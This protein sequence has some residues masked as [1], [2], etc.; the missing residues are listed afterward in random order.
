MLMRIDRLIYALAAIILA[1][2]VSCKREEPEADDPTLH[3]AGMSQ[4]E[5]ESRILGDWYVDIDGSEDLDIGFFELDIP[6][7][8]SS[9]IAR[10]IYFDDGK[11]SGTESG[12]GE[13]QVA[14]LYSVEASSRQEFKFDLVTRLDKSAYPD[15]ID[16][17]EHE[18]GAVDYVL[19][20]YGISDITEETLTL[21]FTA[22]EE[23]QLDGEFTFQRGSVDIASLDLQKMQA[24]NMEIT[25]AETIADTDTT[26]EE[27]PEHPR[28]K[29]YQVNDYSQWMKDIPDERKVC[30]LMIPGSHDSGTFNVHF[31]M[32]TFGQTQELNIRQMWD[33]GCRAYDLRPRKE[34]NN[35]AYI[36]HD[37]IP[38]NLKF[39]DAFNEIVNLVREH[40]ETDGAIVLIHPEGNQLLRKVGETG[41]S[42]ISWIADH[43]INVQM[44]TD[45]L[46]VGASWSS[47]D[48]KINE[49]RS[50]WDDEILAQFR[51]DMTMADLR[52]KVLIIEQGYDDAHVVSPNV[53]LATGWGGMLFSGDKSAKATF[54]AQNNW[55][56]ESGD[57]DAWIEA[58]E[59]EFKANLESSSKCM[60]DVTW[61]ANDAS[62]FIKAS[63]LPDYSEAAAKLYPKFIDLLNKTPGRGIVFQDFFG[64]QSYTRVNLAQIIAIVYAAETLIPLNIPGA[65]YLR[66]QMVRF[67]YWLA[68]KAKDEDKVRGADL[69]NAVIANNFLR[70]YSFDFSSPAEES[71]LQQMI[72]SLNGCDAYTASMK[73]LSLAGATR[74]FE[75][76]HQFMLDLTIFQENPYVIRLLDSFGNECGKYE[77]TVENL[78]IT[79]PSA[80]SDSESLVKDVYDGTRHVARICNEYI[81]EI[82]EKAR[83]NVVY[84]VY[85]GSVDYGRGL[86]VGDDDHKP[87][88]VKWTACASA[89]YDQ[90]YSAT[91]TVTVLTDE[92]YG[93]NPCVKIVGNSLLLGEGKKPCTLRDYTVSAT[94]ES[95]T[96]QV[97]TVKIGA[98][99][100]TRDYYCATRWQNGST[101]NDTKNWGVI[102]KDGIYYY[103]VR[104]YTMDLMYHGGLCPKGWWI[105]WEFQ[106]RDIKQITDSIDE[107]KPRHTSAAAWLEGGLLGLN[108]KDTGHLRLGSSSWEN[109]TYSVSY[110]DKACLGYLSWED[111][112]FW[113]NV[114]DYK[115]GSSSYDSINHMVIYEF[116]GTVEYEHWS[117]GFDDGWGS[118]W[119]SDWKDRGDWR[120]FPIL[121]SQ[122]VV[123][124]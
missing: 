82:N 41:W 51:P 53:A 117:M 12:F 59:K 98:Y 60:D 20:R 49:V 101:M 14:L 46:N 39:Y 9:S 37:M 114:Y 96:R 95:G 57:N 106:F 22:A 5:V 100:Y 112:H 121:L 94:N 97:N 84:P 24:L 44:S 1:I 33:Q 21:C 90:G 13:A 115:R 69:K 34:G 79:I 72:S 62:G 6:K 35:E 83:V 2:T 8:A 68:Y 105:P 17:I 111:L 89:T 124:D 11:E 80:W 75:Q 120:N 86:F 87:S 43:L 99:I 61:Y 45:D 56:A 3:L 19:A 93:F 118:Y 4:S 108:L 31:F 47:V 26:P 122:R 25:A 29:A 36:F 76:V 109:R 50:Y 63:G 113:D 103:S 16:Q 102:Y 23:T 78:G 54:T 28:T 38:C 55:G 66:E 58:K 18:L 7:L 88:R 52:G 42:I 40:R 123:T 85:S 119:C 15:Y 110:S 64:L 65:S 104:T 30:Q 91:P 67:E 48:Q 81:P 71:V 32:R 107:R 74:R 27:D 70:S 73:D 116:T 77:N 10:I 92:F